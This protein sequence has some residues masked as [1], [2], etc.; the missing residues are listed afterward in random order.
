MCAGS[1]PGSSNHVHGSRE[2][3]GVSIIQPAHH[4]HY[5]LGWDGVTALAT[6]DNCQHYEDGARRGNVA[7]SLGARVGSRREM[8]H[9]SGPGDG[10]ELRSVPP[11]CIQKNRNTH[12]VHGQPS[13]NKPNTWAVS[14]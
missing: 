11:I 6:I 1:S 2:E 14:A 13:L 5:L 10:T 8:Y 12:R 4:L 3:E 7:C 9:L